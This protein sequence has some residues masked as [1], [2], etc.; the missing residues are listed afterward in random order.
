MFTG[1]GNTIN[2][3]KHLSPKQALECCNNG[4]IIIDVREEFMSHVKTF[5]VPEIKVFPL[6][7]MSELVG[8]LPKDKFLIFA[9]AT[10]VKSKPAMEFASKNG[11]AQIANLAGGLLEWE[12]DG[13]PTI[14]YQ[15]IKVSGRNKCEFLHKESL[16]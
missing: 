6:K 9:D 1:K 11:Y 8:K 5:D 7:K 16:K 2:N 4:A 10:G 12:R 14:T 15:K 3:L 13:L